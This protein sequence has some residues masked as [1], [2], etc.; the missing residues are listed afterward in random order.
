MY[1]PSRKASQQLGCHPV[2][3]AACPVPNRETTLRQA[4]DTAKTSEVDSTTCTE[5]S[6]SVSIKGLKPYWNAQCAKNSSWL[7]LP[8]KTANVGLDSTLYRGLLSKTLEKSWF[9]I[10]LAFPQSTNLSPTYSPSFT[11]LRQAQSTASH[12][13]Y[14]DLEVIKAKLIKIY[15]NKEQRKL[16]KQ[17]LGSA[18]SVDELVESYVYNQ[19]INY[20]HSCINFNPTWQEV[21]NDLLKH[22]PTWCDAIPFQIKAMAVKIAHKAFWDAKGKPHYKSRKEPRQSC[23]IPKSS[24][25][26]KGIYPRVSGKGLHYSEYFDVAQYKS[27]PEIPLDSRLVYQYGEW[28]LSVPHRVTLSVP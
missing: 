21:R 27:L 25:S 18:R 9:S 11:S 12:A 24:V 2:A 1:I 26:E 4:Q 28:F 3:I 13:D 8:T 20:L 15:P 23:Y 10:K 16:F 22:L 7:W 6:R 17:W 5:Q 14:T 19:A